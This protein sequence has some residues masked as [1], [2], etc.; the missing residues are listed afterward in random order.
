MVEGGGEMGLGK[1]IILQHHVQTI[2]IQGRPAMAAALPHVCHPQL[3]PTRH[4][5]HQ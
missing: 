1:P 5:C 2:Q 4:P 3:S